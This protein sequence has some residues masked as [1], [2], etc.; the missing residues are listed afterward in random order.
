MPPAPAPADWNLAQPG[1]G[2]DAETAIAGGSP[3]AYDS[4]GTQAALDGA[5]LAYIAQ[6][7][8]SSSTDTGFNA[9]GH[10]VEAQVRWEDSANIL[11]VSPWSA[12]QFLV[13]V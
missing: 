9:A 1:P 10:T 3:A 5:P 11:P 7:L 8:Q 4:F 12:S 2:A 13:L 6:N